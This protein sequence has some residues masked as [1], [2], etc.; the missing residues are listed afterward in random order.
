MKIISLLFLFTFACL[1][2]GLY[3]AQSYQLTVLKDNTPIRDTPSSTG[4]VLMVVTAGTV[5]YSD[6]VREGWYRVQL[7]ENAGKDVDSGYIFENRVEAQPVDAEPAPREQKRVS[8]REAERAGNRRERPLLMNAYI[9]LGGAAIDFKGFFMQVGCQL[10]LTP[11]FYGE[12]VTEMYL[13]PNDYSSDSAI[14]S[15][16]LNG[17][18]KFSLGGGL[19]FYMLGGVSLTWAEAYGY[20]TTYTSDIQF[21]LNAGAGVEIALSREFALRIGSMY[22]VIFDAGGSLNVVNFFGGLSY[23]F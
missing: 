21:G 17:V 18:Y 4:K 20:Y 12:V 8:V 7:P 10:A 15:L 19:K 2:P 3:G 5:L 14:Y 6:D 22:K 11:E 16:D 9:D 13:N 1:L 23:C